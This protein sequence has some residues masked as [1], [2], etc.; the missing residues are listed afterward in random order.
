MD[1]M[2]TIHGSEARTLCTAGC[3]VVNG[4]GHLTALLIQYPEFL[5]CGIAFLACAAWLAWQPY[6]EKAGLL[7]AACLFGI[8]GPP[9]ANMILLALSSMR[10]LGVDH[11]IF[12]VDGLLRFQPS[13]WIGML[14]EDHKWLRA[15][16]AFAYNALPAV[17]VGV[18]ALYIFRRPV[19]E[20][21]CVALTFV[22]NLFAAIP[23]YLLFPCYGPRAA[24]RSFPRL[25]HWHVAMQ[26]AAIIGTPNAI[27][28]VHFSSA[29]LILWFLWN[30][31]SGRVF[32]VIFA[33][34]TILATLGSGEHYLFDLVAA[35]PYT[36]AII[37]ITQRG[38]R[39]ILNAQAVGLAPPPPPPQLSGSTAPKL[40][41]PVVVPPGKTPGYP[42]PFS[43]APPPAVEFRE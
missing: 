28:S 8:I 42:V 9:V 35:V 34:L 20:G 27:P 4:S 32:G 15:M 26:R 14:L 18:F 19:G 24:F 17:Y 13:F 12:A 43:A 40:E 3:G 31:R 29:L 11:Y 21:R 38:R 22:T 6:C 7:T 41:Y 25:P 2:P 30:W 37:A 39:S 5:I 1:Q 23:I 16:S 33:V 10:P 36:G